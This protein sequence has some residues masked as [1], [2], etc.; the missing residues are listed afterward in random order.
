[1]VSWVKNRTQ[2]I[3]LILVSAII[4]GGVLVVAG[5]LLF[6]SVTNYKPPLSETITMQNQN[7]PDTIPVG[8]MELYTWN[9]GHCGWGK[10]MNLEGAGGKML[11]PEP[12]LYERYRDGIVYQLTTLNKLDF[13]LLQDVDEKSKRSFGDNQLERFKASFKEYFAAFA[14]NYK[15]PFIPFPLSKPAGK[16]QAGML[17]LSK[18]APIETKRIS[19]PSVYTWPKSLIMPDNGCLLTRYAVSNGKQLVLINIHNAEPLTNAHLKEKELSLLKEIIELEFSKGNY[20]IAGGDW[21]RNPIGFKPE[22]MQDGYKAISIKPAIAATYLPTGYTWA[23]DPKYPSKRN[24]DLAYDKEKALTTITDFFILSP[25]IKLL[26]S[27]TLKSNFEFSDH[28]AVGM[29]VELE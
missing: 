20:V 28:Q 5:F 24:V 12:A 13:I 23:Y 17:T 8:K 21:N 22:N 25:N 9:I 6:L 18:Y 4:G 11:Q 29:I 10:E 16:V 14:L 1:M 2:K 15:V 27:N 26:T 3:I 7:H 19:F